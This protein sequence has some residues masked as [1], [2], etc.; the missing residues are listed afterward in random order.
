MGVPDPKTSTGGNSGTATGVTLN[1]IGFGPGLA[2]YFEPTNLYLSATL[3]FSQITLTDSKTNNQLAETEIG[4]GF[5]G[6]VG[7]EWW[8][9]TDWG[10]GLAAQFQL[11]S[12]KV[13]NVDSR[14]TGMGFALLFS[15]TYN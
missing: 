7:K 2:Y 11:A 15:A 14:M 6:M 5:S 12:V 10:L 4:Y 1:M 3:N 8:V 9:S 13:K